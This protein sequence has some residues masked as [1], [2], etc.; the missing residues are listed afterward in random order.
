MERA[1]R[2]D[3]PEKSIIEEFIDDETFRAEVL[4]QLADF[5]IELISGFVSLLD[6]CGLA[7]I[8]GSSE[9][10]RTKRP[11]PSFSLRTPPAVFF[12]IVLRMARTATHLAYET[13]DGSPLRR[14]SDDLISSPNAR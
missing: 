13:S 2:H 11:A 3:A 4:E 7:G 8:P 10:T 14:F 6:E 1:F 5:Q 12:F 9:S